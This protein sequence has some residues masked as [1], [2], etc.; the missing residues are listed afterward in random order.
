MS[1]LEKYFAPFRENI[2]GLD[3]KYLSPYGEQKIVYGDWIASGRL[4]AP[5]EKRL[6]EEFGPF[7][8]NTHTEASETGTLMTKSYHYAHEADQ[9]ACE[10]RT[11]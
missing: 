2:I 11:Q 8:A 5:I 9:A 7:V 6:S 1:K 10:C 3:T 4:Y